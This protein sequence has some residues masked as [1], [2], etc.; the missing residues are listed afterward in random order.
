MTG[1]NFTRAFYESGLIQTQQYSDLIRF[2]AIMCVILA[3]MWSLHHFLGSE[4]KESDGFM[5]RLGTRSV[6][7][8]IGLML[9]IIFLTT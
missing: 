5:V 9:F 1:S 2:L 7:I 3:M 8:A 4:A 6:R